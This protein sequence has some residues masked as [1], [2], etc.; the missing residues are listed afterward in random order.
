MVI[1]TSSDRLAQ[2]QPANLNIFI[3]VCVC[4]CVCVYMCVCVCVFAR[5]Y[6]SIYTYTTKHLYTLQERKNLHKYFSPRR[7]YI[8]IYTLPIFFSKV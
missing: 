5:A 2:T 7:Y 6:V 8:Y 1:W 3:Y 4:V